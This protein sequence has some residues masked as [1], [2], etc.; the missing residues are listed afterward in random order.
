[1][2]K[3][4]SLRSNSDGDRPNSIDSQSAFDTLS[5]NQRVAFSARFVSSV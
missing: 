2:A 4:M 3:C 5:L 1:M